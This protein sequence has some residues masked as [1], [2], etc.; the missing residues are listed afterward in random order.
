MLRELKKL[1]REQ[2]ELPAP[3]PSQLSKS[4]DRHSEA[5]AQRLH[6]EQVLE[7]INGSF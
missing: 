5:R 2:G 4:L 3:V 6:V 1:L 7:R